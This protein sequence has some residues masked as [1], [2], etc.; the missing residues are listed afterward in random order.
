MAKTYVVIG[1]CAMAKTSTPMGPRVL[2]FLEGA[3]LPDDVEQESI[4]HLLD[5]G[6]IAPVGSAEAK[7]AGPSGQQPQPAPDS[8]PNAAAMTSADDPADF[9]ADEVLTHL[10]GSDDAERDRTLAAEAGGKARK[11]VL[12]FEA[13][14]QA[15]APA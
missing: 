14:A 7:L 1:A 12:A 5:V 4:D 2:T 15:H 11:S 10:L 9:T 8:N 13:P 6:L 3:V